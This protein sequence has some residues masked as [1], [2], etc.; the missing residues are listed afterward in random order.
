MFDLIILSRIL[1]ISS[2]DHMQVSTSAGA[3]NSVIQ[4]IGSLYDSLEATYG[5][6]ST[7]LY[8]AFRPT[9]AKSTS[10]QECIINVLKI[11]VL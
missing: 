8:R 7:R 5:T 10:P 11:T 1:L 2:F 9:P 4:I 6:F 3:E